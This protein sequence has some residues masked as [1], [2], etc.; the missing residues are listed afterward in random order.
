ME[1]TTPQPA[2]NQTVQMSTPVT[3]GRAGRML[4]FLGLATLAMMLLVQPG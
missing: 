4:A 2:A 1:P 3:A